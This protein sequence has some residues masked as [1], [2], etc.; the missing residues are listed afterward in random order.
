[1]AITSITKS[2]PWENYRAKLKAFFASDNEVTVGEFEG[3]DQK[4]VTITV[5]NHSKADALR[6]LLKSSVQFGNITV[7]VN[8]EYD[9]DVSLEKKFQYAFTGNKY[10]CDFHRQNNVGPESMWSANYVL[11]KPLAVQYY[12]DNLASYYGLES[13]LPED[14]A[15]DILNPVDGVYYCSSPAGDLACPF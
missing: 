3:E 12:D 10:Y 4:T 9:D 15:R 11:F 1:M 5:K 7:N 8:V 13:K 2:P 14:V 6:D